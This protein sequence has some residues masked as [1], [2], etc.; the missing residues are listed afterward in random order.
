L[1]DHVAEAAGLL[2]LTKLRAHV[3]AIQEAAQ[4]ARP[5]RFHQVLDNRRGDG[6]HC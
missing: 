1:A 4:H 6:A 3:G 2:S 5:E